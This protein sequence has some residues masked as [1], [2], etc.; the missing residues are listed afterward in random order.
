MKCRDCRELINAYID[1]GMDPMK[2]SLLAEHVGRCDKCRE[3]LDFLV[4]WNKSVKEIK[5]VKAPA[6]FM[7]ELRRRIEVERAHPLKRYIDKLNEFRNSLRFPVEAVALVVI[8]SVI[9]VLYRP[10]RF[11]LHRVNAPVSESSETVPGS[12]KIFTERTIEK[13]AP[14][15]NEITSGSTLKKESYEVS[16]DEVFSDV[17]EKDK[18]SGAIS[19]KDSYSTADESEGI[20]LESGEPSA[21]EEQEKRMYD[22]DAAAGEKKDEYRADSRTRNSKVADASGLTPEDIFRKYRVV[23]VKV[24]NAGNGI[25]IY[26]VSGENST[27]RAMLDELSARFRIKVKSVPGNDTIRKSVIIIEK[28]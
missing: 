10:D 4:S 28:D 17:K 9:F 5:P 6:G 3:E 25:K 16:D 7:T 2:D 14:G 13:S 19:G 23:I 20:M 22:S 8:G 21:K 18:S 11:M 12:E 15:K 27:N 24:E 26:T 1:N